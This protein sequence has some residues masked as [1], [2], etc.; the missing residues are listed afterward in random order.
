MLS[1]ERVM[2]VAVVFSFVCSS[3]KVFSVGGG[4][5]GAWGFFWWMIGDT[6]FF[7][8]TAAKLSHTWRKKVGIGVERN[9]DKNEEGALL[10]WTPQMESSLSAD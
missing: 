5:L 8:E 4:N 2:L 7:S 3:E 6:N 9:R 1:R 10:C